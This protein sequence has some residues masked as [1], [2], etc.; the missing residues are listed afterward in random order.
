MDSGLDSIK[1]SISAGKRETYKEIQ[2][3]DDFDKVI[4][5]LKWISTYRKESGLNFRIYV[6]MVYT[7]K[8]KSEVDGSLRKTN[9][10][11]INSKDGTKYEFSIPV[12]GK[13]GGSAPGL[14]AFLTGLLGV[15][16]GEVV[17][18]QLPL[19]QQLQE[20]Q[21]VLALHPLVQQE[22]PVHEETLEEPTDG[23]EEW[24][25]GYEA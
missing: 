9:F 1:F 5:N 22:E 18:P 19:E 16:I 24:C 15:G 6:T 11:V 2:G 25:E 12:Q 10:R 3:Q 13:K 8:T 4:S 14:G 23:E 20:L 17:M 7:H 21:E